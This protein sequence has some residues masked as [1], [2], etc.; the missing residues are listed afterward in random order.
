MKSVNEAR[1]HKVSRSF[2]HP[3][4]SRFTRKIYSIRWGASIFQGDITVVPLFHEL[5]RSIRRTTSWFEKQ[6]VSNSERWA[7][8]PYQEDDKAQVVGFNKMK[9]LYVTPSMIIVNKIKRSEIFLVWRLM[10][11]EIFPSLGLVWMGFR[12]FF[13]EAHFSLFSV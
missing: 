13:H 8:D 2:G 3:S 4:S 6:E 10:R 11:V 5:L 7:G 9:N 12:R 1:V